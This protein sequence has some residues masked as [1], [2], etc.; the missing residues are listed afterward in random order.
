EEAFAGLMES[1]FSHS[2]P[3]TR[4]AS[5]L[6]KELARRTRYLEHTIEVEL[7]DEENKELAGF[8]KAFQTYLISGLGE[9]EFSDFYAQ[10]VTYGLFAARTRADGT[11]NR[12]NARKFIPATIGILRDVFEFISY[13]ELPQNIGWIVDDIAEILN[14]AKTDKILKRYYDEGKGADPI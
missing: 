11:F 3:V 7:T 9:A 1:F 8:Y 6:A 12:R 14:V 10:T 2:T 4:K 13:R 5:A